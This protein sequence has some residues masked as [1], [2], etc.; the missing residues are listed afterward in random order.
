MKAAQ[1]SQLIGL[2]ASAL[3][4]LPK[5]KLA[6]YADEGFNPF[7]GKTDKD[8][9]A[10]AKEK[11]PLRVAAFEAASKIRETM[12]LRMKEYIPN[13]GGGAFDQNRK[14]QFLGE[15]KE[16]ALAILDLEETLDTMKKLDE[17]REKETN[18]RWL[19]HFDMARAR[20]MSRLVYINEYNN[21]IAQIRTDSLPALEEK[22]HVGW[23]VNTSD[24]VQIKEAKVKTMVKDVAK[25]WTRMEKDYPMTPWA[26][27]AKREKN[28]AMGMKW[29]PTRE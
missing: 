27:I 24:R 19:A 1:V 8:S 14:K 15:Q 3:P 4:V 23:R 21:L 20:L 13:P 29:V 9:L 7:E 25:L 10:K 22:I 11:Y 26:I 5:E 18:K 2:K 28:I 16:P 12:D 17:D 6:D